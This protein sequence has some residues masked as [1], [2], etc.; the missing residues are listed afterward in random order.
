MTA[1]ELTWFVKLEN[2]FTYGALSTATLL[3][4]RLA[5]LTI[6]AIFALI[7]FILFFSFFFIIVFGIFQILKVVE[8]KFNTKNVLRL[9]HCFIVVSKATFLLRSTYRLV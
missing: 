2:G 4:G 7:V 8:I 1:F 5:A 9:L 3:L 6:F